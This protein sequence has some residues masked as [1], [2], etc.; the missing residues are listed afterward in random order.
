MMEEEGTELWCRPW[1]EGYT[2]LK[3][4]AVRG[5]CAVPFVPGRF[6]TWLLNSPKLSAFVVV[7]LM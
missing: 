4:A 3:G 1:H 2:L 6:G 7:T 5:G